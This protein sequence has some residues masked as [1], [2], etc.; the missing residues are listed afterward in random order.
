MDYEEIVKNDEFHRWFDYIPHDVQYMKYAETNPSAVAAGFM[1]GEVYHTFAYARAS[2]M[3]S[4]EKD[5]GDLAKQ[6]DELSMLTIKSIL[7]QNVISQYSICEDLSWQVIWAYIL[8]SDIQ[9]LMNNEY[10]KMGKECNRDNLIA[11]LDCGIGQHNLTAQK[12]KNILTS[13]D[14]DEEVM[15]FRT[16]NNYLKHRGTIHI[17]GL[18][19]DDNSLMFS[20]EGRPISIRAHKTYELEELQKMAWTYHKKFEKYFNEIIETI[21]PD[22]YLETK[23]SFVDGINAVIKMS[24]AQK[25]E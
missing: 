22:D 1:I 10:E 25:N 19:N 16:L 9:Y 12:L 11:Q 3:F 7:I 8:P 20:I 21:M 24:N 2:L 4:L 6:T 23:I 17:K 14:N 5:Y 18:G 13:F 15:N